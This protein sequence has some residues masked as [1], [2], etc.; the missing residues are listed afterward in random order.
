MASENETLAEIEEESRSGEYT[1][2]ADLIE[3]AWKSE[4]EPKPLT[5]P[6]WIDHEES[7]ADIAAVLR[8]YVLP[9]LADRLEAAWKRERESLLTKQG[10]NVNSGSAVYT[11]E[12]KGGNSAAMREA[13]DEILE[14][15]DTWRTDGSMEHWQ[16]SQLFDIADAALSAPPRNCDVGTAEEQAKR[17]KGF[18]GQF[19]CYEC[20]LGVGA[21][22]VYYC[23][24]KWAQ[25]PYAE[26]EGGANA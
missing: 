19:D 23:A 3:A 26:E 9:S 5:I 24:L 8:R 10:E 18:C 12:N 15:I 4:R 6:G 2:L 22:K 25:M 11:G 17:F 21:G 7:I 14:R 1:P 16:Y 20:P 13:L